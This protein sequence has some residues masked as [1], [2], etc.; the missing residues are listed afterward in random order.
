MP[1][2]LV[3]ICKV[4]STQDSAAIAPLL[5]AHRL[6]DARWPAGLVTYTGPPTSSGVVVTEVWATRGSQKHF[7]AAP[8]Q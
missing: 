1:Y 5:D 6:R 2:G 3:L 4:V 8:M 7:L